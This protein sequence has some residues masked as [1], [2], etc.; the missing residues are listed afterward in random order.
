MRGLFRR[1]RRKCDY[2]DAERIELIRQ[3]YLFA[4]EGHQGQKRRTGEAYITHPVDVA[5]VLAEYKLDHQT[6]IAALLHDTIED[7]YIEKTDIAERFG[8]DVASIVDGVSKLDKIAF[9][10]RVEAQAENFRKMILA[11]SKDIRVILVKLA[12]RLHNMRT[13]GSLHAQKK[14]RIA[15]ETLEIYAPIAKRLGMRELS[16]E[17]EELSFADLYPMRYRALKDSVKRAR[18][19]RKKILTLIERTF[20]DGLEQASFP[21]CSIE[22]REKHLY[23]IYR[24]MHRKHLT[25]NEIMDVY[26]FRLIVDEVDTCYR[27][28]GLVHRL[29]KPVPERFKD[30]IA[31]PKANGYQSL[32]TTLFGPYGLPIEVQIRT[33]EMDRFANQGIAAHWVY[34]KSSTEEELANSQQ[35]AQE[36]VDNLLAMQ[37][38]S[39]SSLEF[40]ESVKI[41]LFPDEVYVFTPRGDIVSLPAGATAVDLAYTVHT[42]IGNHCLSARIDRQV[43]SLSTP[44]KNGQTVQILTSPSA[45]PNPAWLDF[46]V[47]GKARSAIRHYL[48]TRK[49]SDSI[50]LGK[51]LLK[52]ALAALGVSM[53]KLPNE[54]IAAV[55]DTFKMISVDELFEDIGL[56]NRVAAMVAQQIVQTVPKEA[57]EEAT[58]TD[59]VLPLAIQGTEGLMI[60]LAPCCHPIPGDPLMGIIRV[61]HGVKVHRESC[62]R[63]QRMRRHPE[64]MVPLRWEKDNDDEEFLTVLHLE[65]VN[66][67]GVLADVATSASLA[68]TNIEDIRVIDRQE[69]HS[70]VEIE[71]MVS[72]R[73]HLSEVFKQLRCVRSVVKITRP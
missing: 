10:S 4:A 39:G 6:I 56:G 7:T 46:V 71:L 2:L 8:E 48:K 23:S 69:A 42:D 61:G 50:T 67:R 66:E 47:T 11:M 30:Y 18:G 44:L 52:R 19:N 25:F 64:R 59:D 41:D 31:I 16:V 29:F 3:A 24:K 14:R 70:V 54:Q 13:L 37:R 51:Q 1:L 45:R 15:R 28:L 65:L 62:E 58:Q 5:C 36:W 21:T 68:G 73:D 33:T 53:K 26:A 57:Q 60:E 40:I 63:L 9:V 17:L 34:K 38:D 22:G 72:S 20:R 12:D 35:H 43:S 32:H 27:V 49:Q 55:L